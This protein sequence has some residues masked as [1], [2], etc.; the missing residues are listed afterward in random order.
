[1]IG[2][3]WYGKLN[4]SCAKF[5]PLLIPTLYFEYVHHNLW[6]KYYGTNLYLG[7]LKPA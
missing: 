7:F 5:S 4:P 2:K 6:K 3:F 1:L